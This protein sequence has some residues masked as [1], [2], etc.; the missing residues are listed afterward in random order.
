MPH[1][2]ARFRRI[3]SLL[4][5]ALLS[6]SFVGMAASVDEPLQFRLVPYL[7]FPALEAEAKVTVD[8][9]RGVGGE[10]LGP[11]SI[12][13]R[14]DPG[15]YLSNLNMAFMLMGELR[16]GRWSLYSDVLYTRFGNK[17]TKLRDVTG[18]LGQVST[19]VSRDAR[20]DLSTTVWT[21]APG[22]RAIERADLE[23]DLM[24]GARYLTMDSDVKVK[25]TG[26]DGAVLQEQTV[27][28][29][30][31]V[32]DGIVGLRGQIL[33]PG[34]DWFVPYYADVGTGESKLTWQ[35]MVGLGYRFDWGETTLAFRALS[36]DFDDNDADL[37]LYGPGLAFGFQW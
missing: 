20:T 33:F 30:E 8:D 5:M 12:D 35:A 31:H 26:P 28:L 9:V 11:I 6:W 13:G 17:D 25:V 37:R 27:S 1:R 21:L 15:N 3:H 24:A 29:D 18:P 36:Y 32:W 4:L 16:K 34:S 19:A 23:L 7:W 2:R 10:E 14:V 22:Y